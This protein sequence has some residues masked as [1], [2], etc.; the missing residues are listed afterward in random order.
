MHSSALHANVA[1]TALHSMLS[2]GQ[3]IYCAAFVYISL[4]HRRAS[5]EFSAR[6]CMQ[7]THNA[8]SFC[9]SAKQTTELSCLDQFSLS[10]TYPT[11]STS[12]VAL[13][14]GHTYIGA[15]EP[16]KGDRVAIS[17]LGK[18]MGS[19]IVLSV[20]PEYLTVNIGLMKAKVGGR[21]AATVARRPVAAVFE[22]FSAFL[23]AYSGHHSIGNTRVSNAW[24]AAALV[25]RQRNNCCLRTAPH[26]GVTIG[27]EFMD[28]SWMAH[29]CKL[30]QGLTDAKVPIT[31]CRSRTP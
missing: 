7:P 3:A 11:Y 12:Q 6:P 21:T 14:K 26:P 1:F 20:G 15:D 23:S 17:R 10:Q 30:T 27:Q 29:G 31:S 24:Y 8:A 13:Y 22:C 28:H 18:L 4:M 2:S 25:L 16:R 9:L 19:G 5:A